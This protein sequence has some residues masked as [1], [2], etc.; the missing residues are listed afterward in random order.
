MEREG[1]PLWE[2][3]TSPCGLERFLERKL[4]TAIWKVSK[5][6]NTKKKAYLWASVIVLSQ[7]LTFIAAILP[8][9]S[10]PVTSHCLSNPCPSDQWCEDVSSG[11]GNF[12]CIEPAGFYCSFDS[13]FCQWQNVSS[14]N[15]HWMRFSEYGSLRHDHT[16]TSCAGKGLSSKLVWFFSPAGV[17]IRQKENLHTNQVAQQAGAYPGFCSMKRP[18]VFIFSSGLVADP[19]QGHLPVLNSP[20]LIY[21][22]Q[23][24]GALWESSIL[25]R[26]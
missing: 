20:V 10:S 19:S 4:R 17:T 5:R 24:R 6:L 7:G 9:F 14:N 15:Q 18:G 25:P 23:W 1:S 2:W 21:I 26:K 16:N 13:G 22:P 8:E 3:A 11:S 12:T